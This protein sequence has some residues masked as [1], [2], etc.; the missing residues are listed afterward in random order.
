[1]RWVQSETNGGTPVARLPGEPE[2]E[3]RARRLREG[4]PIDPATWQEIVEAA[5]LADLK[6]V[7]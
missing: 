6:G 2:L 7:P 1:V 5:E 4:I 3:T